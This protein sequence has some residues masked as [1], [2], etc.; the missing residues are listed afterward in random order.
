MGRVALLG[1]LPTSKPPL[2]L[3]SADCRTSGSISGTCNV[4]TGICTCPPGRRLFGR[5]AR[6]RQ[7]PEAQ[8]QVP[9][10]H[11]HPRAQPAAINPAWLPPASSL[12]QAGSAAT[13][14]CPAARPTATTMCTTVASAAPSAKAQKSATTACASRLAVLVSGAAVAVGGCTLSHLVSACCVRPKPHCSW[15]GVPHRWRLQ[16]RLCM[17]QRVHVYLHIW[18]CVRCTAFRCVHLHTS[19]AFSLCATSP[20]VTCNGICCSS[21]N[22]CAR[23]R[24]EC[25][26]ERYYYCWTQNQ[27]GCHATSANKNP[28][29]CAVSLGWPG[30]QGSLCGVIKHRPPSAD[31]PLQ[32]CT[33]SDTYCGGDHP[34]CSG[35]NCV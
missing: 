22:V 3:C 32:A 13:P 26:T 2:P 29:V 33:S 7:L 5:L 21:G 23:G 34:T 6:A 28:Y 16:Q 19:H 24:C 15:F 30:V 1:E 31:A 17:R 27:Q 25:S 12:L 4:A 18:R 9:C 11:L 8:L 14:M 35:T 10:T 20:A